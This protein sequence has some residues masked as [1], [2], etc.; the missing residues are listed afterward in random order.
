MKTKSSVEWSSIFDAADIPF[1]V[2]GTSK[3]AMNNEQLIHNNMIVE[4]EDPILGTIKQPGC[5]LHLS[6]SPNSISPL[7]YVTKDDLLAS[8]PFNRIV[9]KPVKF[10][11]ATEMPLKGIKVSDITNVIAGPSAGRVLADLGADVYKIEPP[12]GDLSRP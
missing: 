10:S 3:S 2:V 4:T 12:Y 6:D 9:Y 7:A 8:F 1:A 11:T 5:S